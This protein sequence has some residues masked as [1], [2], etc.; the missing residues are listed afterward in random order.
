[1]NLKKYMLIAWQSSVGVEDADSP[2]RTVERVLWFNLPSDV[3][4]VIDISD[5]HAFPVLRTSTALISALNDKSAFVLQDDPFSKLLIPEKKIDEKHKHYRDQAWEEIAPLL[6]NESPEFMLYKWVRG[7]MISAHCAR[8]LRTKRGKHVLL[9][10]VTVNKR[11]RLWWQSGCKKNAFLPQFYNCGAPGQKRVSGAAEVSR[12]N[13]QLGRRS[14]LTIANG[15]VETGM[16]VRLT[17]ESKRI[18]E[19][20]VKNYLKTG[21]KWSRT[22]AFDYISHNFFY[23]KIEM[24]GGV[25]TPILFPADKRPS[26]NQFRYWYETEG[27]D[28]VKEKK[29][30]DGDLAYELEGRELLGDSTQMGS[31]PGSLYQI[32]ATIANIFL[33]SSLDPTR[34]IGRPVVY[35]GI[36]VFS[37]VLPGFA[38]NLE[39]PSW[40]GAMLALDNIA[41]DKVAFC[42][43]YGITID[44]YQWPCTGLPEAI[45]ADRGEFEGYDPDTLINSFDMLIH[46]TGPYRADWKGLIERQFGIADEK[47]VKFSP[48]YVP[49]R[50]RTR[51]NPDYDLTAA[52]TLNDFRKLLICYVLSYNLNHYLKGYRKDKFMI[53]DHVQRYP[54]DI[55]HWGIKHRSGHL[56]ELAHDIIRLN[57]LPRK[58][59]SV[60][61]RGIHFQDEL[62]YTCS[63]AMKEN[64]FPRAR[65]KGDWRIE[66]AFD[67]RTT[68][69]IYLPLNGGLGLERCELTPASKHLRGRDWYEVM[70]YFALETVAF[71][72]AAT[73]IQ[74]SNANLTAQANKIKSEAVE[75]ARAARVAVGKQSKS[76][77][78]RDRRQNRAQERQLE[79]EH[80]AW[81]LGAG[82]TADKAISQQSTPSS[83]ESAYV[84]PSSKVARIRELR[85]RRWAKK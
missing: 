61:A 27:C 20:G 8:S 75:R 7:P 51:G 69:Y 21:E 46:N 68:D 63:L 38:V 85:D 9:S 33:V 53:A 55:W 58:Q 37:H 57:L 76:S 18:L 65:L 72:A 12:N 47:V 17:Q 80:N 43:E 42:A 28:V 45:L 60:T 77:R 11:L 6:E 44:E 2:S 56:G 84:P 36:D 50:K 10:R 35:G 67:P 24:V 16:G 82:D 73:R 71:Q 1:M 26:F 41:M 81:R 19:R 48:G 15:Q 34:I 49:P 70:D 23:E 59:V 62:Y 4:I 74:Q 83:V 39:G 64:W 29:A 78:R 31:G 54:L 66:I 25:P 22:R 32:D 52:L 30:R 3:V 5:P 79:R 40:L 13:P 14:A